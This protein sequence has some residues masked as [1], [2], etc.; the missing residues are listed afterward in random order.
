MTDKKKPSPRKKRLPASYYNAISLVG[1]AIAA[2]SLSLIFFMMAL[3]YFG[4]GHNPYVGVIAFLI[5]PGFLVIGLAIA[6][7]G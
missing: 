6:A 3:E 5:L 1:A 2:I 4:D 7:F